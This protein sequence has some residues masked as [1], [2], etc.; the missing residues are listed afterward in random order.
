LEKTLFGGYSKIKF[1][2]TLRKFYWNL[3]SYTWD[4]Y[5]HL[6]DYAKEIEEIT[7]IAEKYKTGDHPA[8]LDLG[9]ATGS[10]S[11]TL[12]KKHFQVTGID[13]AIK[14]I[15]KANKREKDSDIRNVS[16]LHADYNRGLNF[17]SSQFDFVLS[18][19]TIQ[20]KGNR[21]QIIKEINRVLKRD[22]YFLLVV[23]KKSPKK[24]PEIKESKI[25]LR[26]LLKTI[27]LLFL[28][29]NRKIFYD[30][31]SIQSQSES[32]GF[33]TVHKSETLHNQIILFK[34]TVD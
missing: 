29:G 1:N 2:Y 9:C 20:G 23:K 10:Y 31:D 18:A 5:L 22:G 30:T 15:C 8:L 33:T 26:F 12:A 24:V 6:T 13:Y 25:F 14:M 4:D 34:K 27:K 17:N 28:S 19:H 16:F 11:F 7:Q 32:L 21:T 3:H